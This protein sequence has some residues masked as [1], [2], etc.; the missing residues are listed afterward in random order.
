M[1]DELTYY[2]QHSGQLSNKFRY[3]QE[4]ATLYVESGAFDKS[5]I[6]FEI[7]ELGYISLEDQIKKSISS[8][9]KKQMYKFYIYSKLIRNDTRFK[10]LKLLLGTLLVKLINFMK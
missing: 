7:L 10:R 8:L 6:K 9:P 2:R 5:Q 1:K 4:L 3:A